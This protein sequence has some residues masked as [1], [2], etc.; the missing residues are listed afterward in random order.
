MYGTKRSYPGGGKQPLLLCIDDDPQVTEAIQLRLRDY[1]IDVRTACHGMHGFYE[2]MSEKPDLII[3]DIHMPQGEGDYLVEC[4]Q[5]NCERRDIPIIVLT[6]ERDPTLEGRMCRL[7]AQEYF[8]KPVLFEE[9]RDA[10][11]RYLP[12]RKR[13]F[14]KIGR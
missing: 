14:E 9:L 3:T 8:V 12:L 4:L 1:E 11:S 6:G 2:A 10:I 7:G 13:E 5:N